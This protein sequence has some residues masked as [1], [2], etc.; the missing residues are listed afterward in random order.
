MDRLNTALERDF[1]SISTL[2][3]DLVGVEDLLE[4]RPVD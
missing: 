2:K 1:Q 3:N 4:E